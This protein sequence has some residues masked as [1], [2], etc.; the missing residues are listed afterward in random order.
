M[1]KPGSAY[2]ARRT[3]SCSPT[4]QGF[5][6]EL[7]QAEADLNAVYESIKADA[8][9]RLGRLYDAGDYPSE[10]RHVFGLDYD[11]PSV[12][13]PAYL[14]RIAP[15]VYRQ[16][17]QRVAARFEEAVRLAE[18]AF[19]GELSQLVAHLTERLTAG[20]EGTKKVFRDSAVGNL[21]E[22]FEKFRALNI[23]SNAQLDSLV[24]Q[25]RQIVRGVEP[26]AL[27]GQ[28][29]LRQQVAAQLGQVQAALEGLVIDAPRR[30]IVRQVEPRS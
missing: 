17:Q 18:Q 23:G 6:E 30:R 2:Y 7:V 20:P 4:L 3:S 28:E 9:Q 13:P 29:S 25:A 11:F 12:E 26:Q 24:E 21:T 27:R 16:E 14:L 10:I 8:R 1:W 15:D 22:F 19:V 5:Q